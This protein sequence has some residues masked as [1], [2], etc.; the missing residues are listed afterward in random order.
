MAIHAKFNNI[1]VSV[2]NFVQYMKNYFKN[3]RETF[4]KL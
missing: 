2:L 1:P 3:N 4:N